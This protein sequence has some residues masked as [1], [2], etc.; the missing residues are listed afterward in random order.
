MRRAM[1][2]AAHAA[3]RYHPFWK[4]KLEDMRERMRY[5]KAVTAIARKLLVSVWHVLTRMELDRHAIPEQVARRV[6]IYVNDLGAKNRREKV[7]AP[8]ET[9][10]YLDLLNVAHDIDHIQWTK[11]IRVELP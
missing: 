6:Y 2:Q 9:R 5:Q 3:G 10:R 8:M 4:K 11:E 1:V 7:T